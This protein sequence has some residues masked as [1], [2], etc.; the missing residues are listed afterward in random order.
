MQLSRP[1]AGETAGRG[2][3]FSGNLCYVPLYLSGVRACLRSRH[4]RAGRPAGKGGR[5][6][7]GGRA[8]P[9]LARQCA[10]GAR[11]APPVRPDPA[12]QRRRQVRR[13]APVSGA[14]PEVSG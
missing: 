4:D 5:P 12:R 13:A 7:P 6:C 14:G 11:H 9:R 1:P 2:A 8:R 3:G 10:P